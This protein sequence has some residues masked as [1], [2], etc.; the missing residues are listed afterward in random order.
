MVAAAVTLVGVGLLGRLAQRPAIHDTTSPSASAAVAVAT[1]PTPSASAASGRI[2]DVPSEPLQG[3]PVLELWRRD[4]TDA[5]LLAWDPSDPAAGIRTTGR[6]RDLVADVRDEADPLL[7]LSPSG[8]LLLLSA[9]VSEPGADDRATNRVADL[10]GDVLWERQVSAPILVAPAWT[11]VRDDVVIPVASRW[12]HVAFGAARPVE[13]SIT[14]PTF[15]RSPIGSRT[16]PILPVV[17]AF[18]ADGRTAYAA[19]SDSPFGGGLR[20]LFSVDL[21]RNRATEIQRLPSALADESAQA[22]SPDLTRIDP[23]TGRGIGL[24]LPNGGDVRVYGPDGVTTDTI[25]RRPVVLGSTWGPAGLLAILSTDP[26]RAGSDDA[27]TL[28]LVA[29]DGT[30]VRTPFRTTAVANGSVIAA[31][32][33]YLLLV[34]GDP[35]RAELV[36]VR[37]QDGATATT[38]IPSTD[39]PDLRLLGWLPPQ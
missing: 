18:S 2:P 10:H 21:E 1:S 5:V 31:P 22:G 13:H 7:T 17:G 4:G 38:T 36:A 35:S 28:D 8:D 20:P 33:G 6:L 26:A 25:V 11:P 34:F 9:L 3:A 15:D 14:V 12:L 32:N 39:V 29:S 27:T 19:A 16:Q 23:L 24:P 30:A 37:L